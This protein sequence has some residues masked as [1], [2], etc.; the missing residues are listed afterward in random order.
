MKNELVSIVVPIYNVEKYL[1]RCITSIVNQTYKNLEIILVEDGSPDNCPVMCDDW[2]K[3]DNRI[4]VI[5]KENAGLGMARNTGID[6]ASGRYICFF[7]SDDYIDLNTI[8]KAYQNIKKY[9]SDIAIF[10]MY[11]VNKSGKNLTADIPKTDKELYQGEEI[12]QIV[13]PNM[14]SGRN[15]F[16]MSSSGRIYS[17]DMIRKNNWRFVS[18]REYIS[19]DFYSLLE[20]H[21]KV[22]SVSIMHEALYYYCYNEKSLSNSLDSRRFEKV[23]VCHKGMREV[24]YKCQYP[25]EIIREVDSQFLGNII[26]II[27][28]FNDYGMKYEEQK[29]EIKKIV[30]SEYMQNIFKEMDMKNES[31]VRKIMYRTLKNKNVVMVYLLVKMKRC[32]E[33]K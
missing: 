9:N 33:K 24:S 3:K 6:N 15:G 10:G 20:L 1:D 5:H 2:A 22:K 16:N 28:L 32:W 18:E 27:K 8:E 13:L 29:K 7:D 19:E 12:V 11:S 14:L 26:A 30:S 25:N 23:C 4:R 31:F 17:M 21:G